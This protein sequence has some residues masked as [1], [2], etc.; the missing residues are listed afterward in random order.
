MTARGSSGRESVGSSLSYQEVF[1]NFPLFAGT[2]LKIKSY[3]QTIKTLRFNP[4][5]MVVWAKVR[6]QM[7]KGLPVRIV[8]LKARQLGMSTWSQAF[9]L[10][11][12]LHPNTNCLAIAHDLDSTARIF[13]I[14]KLMYEG[15]PDPYRPKVKRSNRREL[16]FENPDPKTRAIDPGL[17][18]RIEIRTA[19]NIGSG[20][21]LTIQVLHISEVAMYQQPELISSSLFPAVPPTPD[22]AIIVESTAHIKG[23]WFKEFWDASVRGETGYT[24][25]FLPWFLEPR[26]CLVGKLAD[27]YLKEPLDDE[28]KELVERLGLAPG[29]IAFRR[30]QIQQFSGNV[31]LFRQEYP[32]TP[33]EAFIS[34]GSPLIPSD[35]IATLEREAVSGVRGDVLG[36]RFISSP[37][38]RMTLWEPPDPSTRYY[39]G[40][41]VSQGVDGGNPSVVQVITSGPVQRQ[42]AEW[43]GWMDPI[44][45]ASVVEEISRWY[46]SAEV[47][48]E[49]NGPGISTQTA[50]RERGVDLFRWRYLN[51]LK[52]GGVT[53]RLGWTTSQSSKPVLVSHFKNYVMSKKLIIRS[54]ELINKELRGFVVD[55]R[56]GAEAAPGFT[57]DRIMA[58]AIASFCDTLSGGEGWSPRKPVEVEYRDPV[59]YDTLPGPG[60]EVESWR[61]S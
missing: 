18:S 44:D 11:K 27:M 41:D 46:N 32:S 42:V 55:S 57:D 23:F 54:Y 8:I 1:K 58:L 35:F 24:P 33:Y 13:E 7:N 26:Y 15:L 40:V 5:Q 39:I 4:A 28:E 31:D 59:F 60:D 14:A 34:V 38:G 25:I 50:L 17:R 12:A 6:E 49:I 16:V 22:S 29:H 20:R 61:W 56:G 30:K 2:F 53:D 10:W 9:V 52:H 3:D 51:T 19:G 47:A 21:G 45:L 43:V 37:E 48:V 36:G